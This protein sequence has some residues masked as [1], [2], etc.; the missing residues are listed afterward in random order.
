MALSSELRCALTLAGMLVAGCAVGEK[1]E[2]T[3]ESVYQEL[4]GDAFAEAGGALAGYERCW[5]DPDDEGW[6]NRTEALAC[7]TDARELIGACASS[8]DDALCA[9]DADCGGGF[10][11]ESHD[12]DIH[13]CVCYEVCG[14][15]ADC[16]ADEACACPAG[17]PLDDGA[18]YH[19]FESFGECLPA[20]CQTGADCASGE[21]G[22]AWDCCGSGGAAVGFYCR[23]DE[24]TCTSNA[25]CEGGDLCS[26]DGARFACI[27]SCTCE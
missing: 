26:W 27:G 17:F 14:E 25:D 9:T 13:G 8:E 22:V 6:V 15:D 19:P 2:P 18:A 4:E 23:S 5:T 10:C 11:G 7:A 3:C 21:C 24:D 1:A 12:W 20:A 16:G